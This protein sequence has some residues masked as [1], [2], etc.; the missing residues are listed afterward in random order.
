MAVVYIH[1]RLD[2]EEVFYV[3]IGV[4]KHRA[5]QTRSRNDFWWNVVNKTG[6]KVEIK[7]ENISYLEAANYEKELVRLF[8]RRDLGL[9]TLVNLTNGGEGNELVSL[10][11]KI[12]I[13]DSLKGKKQSEETKQKRSCTLKEVWKNEDL[14]ELK[15]KQTRDLNELGLIGTKGMTSKKKGKPFQG[16]REKLS[17]SLKSFYAKG[18]KPYNFVTVTPNIIEKII[19]EYKGGVNKFKLHKKYNLNRKIIDRLV[20]N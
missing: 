13:S 16:D 9:G 8:G 15:R 7:H 6:Y 5:Y 18:N 4:N 12:K 10:S 20:A 14:R 2:T 11:T 1:K 3:G 19:C 17:A